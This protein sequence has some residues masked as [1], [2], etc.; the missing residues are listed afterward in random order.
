MVN[1]SMEKYLQ[2]FNLS[3]PPSV[4]A[5][6]LRGKKGSY[7]A[8][9]YAAW[10]A[11]NSLAIGKTFDPFTKGVCITIRVHGGKGWR[12]NRDIDNILKPVLDILVRKQVIL[13]DNCQVV[14]KVC[15]VYLDPLNKKTEAHLEV[16]VEGSL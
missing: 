1:N 14:K 6:W 2:I 13:D 3:V 8:P 4:N 10:I 16:E 5:V 9:K 11:V 15:A 7:I 12:T